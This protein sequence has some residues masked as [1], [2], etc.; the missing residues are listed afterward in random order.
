MVENTGEIVLRFKD[1][2]EFYNHKV[3]DEN[4]MQTINTVNY[5]KSFSIS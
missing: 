4:V 5:I 1:D 3:I 2:E